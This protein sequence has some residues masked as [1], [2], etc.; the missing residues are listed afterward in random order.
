MSAELDKA[1]ADIRAVFRDVPLTPERGEWPITAGVGI[2]GAIV[3]VTGGMGLWAIPY[4]A[5]L[6]IVWLVLR[7]T[8]IVLGRG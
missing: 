5:V 4:A 2:V 7:A 8:L 3:G 1:I 6:V